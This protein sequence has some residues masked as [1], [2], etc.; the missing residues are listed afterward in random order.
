MATRVDG[1]G[2]WVTDAD[3]NVSNFGTAGNFQIGGIF[4]V[5]PTFGI[6]AQYGYNRFGGKDLPISSTKF[7]ILTS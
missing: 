2:Y 5:S 6:K 4:N 7:P 1:R 3:G